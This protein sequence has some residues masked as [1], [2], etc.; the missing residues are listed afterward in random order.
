MVN[1]PPLVAN[2]NKFNLYISS[3]CGEVIDL[4]SKNQ[5]IKSLKTMILHENK[6]GFVFLPKKTFTLL[7]KEVKW[8]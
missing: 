1:F 5:S 8:N 3:A 2:D 6:T 7:I 4:S